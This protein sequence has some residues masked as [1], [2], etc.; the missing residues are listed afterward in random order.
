MSIQVSQVL[1]YLEAH[2]VGGAA[3]DFESLLDMLH[4]I[5]AESNPIDS[6]AIREHFRSVDELLDLLPREAA[7]RIFI[8]TSD[9]CLEF[10]HTAFQ[11]GVLVGMTLMT[12]LNALR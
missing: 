9:L 10:E 4:F 5:Y 8:V 12:E 11:H 7:D 3:G 2:P 1:E 6:A